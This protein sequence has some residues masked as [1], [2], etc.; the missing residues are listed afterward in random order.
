MT[1]FVY[2]WTN[3][4][5]GKWYIG[6][7]KGTP[8][9]GYI[10]SGVVFC[11]AVHKYG[12]ENFLREI[13]YQG[14]YEHDNIRSEVEM[15]F[16]RESNAANN[17]MSYNQTNMTGPDCFSKETRSKIA[18][19]RMGEKNPMWGKTRDSSR[20]EAIN[21][22]NRFY[23]SDSRCRKNSTHGTL[24][25]TST[26]QCVACMNQKADIN[27]RKIPVQIQGQTYESIQVAA[28]LLGVDYS[29]IGRWIAKGKAEKIYH[30]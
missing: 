9:D 29:T 2:K 27:K 3:K 30:G 26:G 14:D 19:S 6:S 8:D 12:I 10:G 5:N 22:K 16:L 7:H 24:R 1:G 11:A 23:N 25:Y 13:L 17:P 4:L 15:K 21:D 28:D 20:K 18:R